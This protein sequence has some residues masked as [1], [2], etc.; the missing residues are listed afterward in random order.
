MIRIIAML[1]LLGSAGCTRAMV[2]ESSTEDS[3]YDTRTDVQKLED[4]LGV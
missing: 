4:R 3:P 1:A 2:R